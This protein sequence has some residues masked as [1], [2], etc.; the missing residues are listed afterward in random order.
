MEAAV[1]QALTI[2][3]RDPAGDILIFMTGGRPSRVVRSFVK[4]GSETCLR[5]GSCLLNAL[6][7]P[8]W[9]A[10]VH[11]LPLMH[12]PACLPETNLFRPDLKRHLTSH[13]FL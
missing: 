11:T 6:A 2:H 3:L 1:K 7:E 8:V 12:C 5:G 13:A 9:Q 4:P 10:P